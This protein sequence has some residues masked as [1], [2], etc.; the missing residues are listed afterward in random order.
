MFLLTE[1]QIDD[2]Q[3]AEGVYDEQHDIPGFLA[4]SCGEP[5]GDGFPG[6]IPDCQRDDPEQICR[7][8]L[9]VEVWHRQLLLGVF[10][11]YTCSE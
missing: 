10:L 6:Q 4:V 8:E 1:F 3:N 11:V 9:G 5:H 2:W 7:D